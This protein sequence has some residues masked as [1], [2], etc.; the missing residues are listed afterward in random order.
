MNRRIV[1]M[2]AALGMAMLALA[3][4]EKPAPGISVVSGST[5]VRAEAVCWS[6]TGEPLDAAKCAEDALPALSGDGV[7]R[8]PVLAGQFVGISVDPS[9]AD[10]GWTVSVSGD[11]L[12][13]QALT[14]TYYR[15]PFPLAT[16]PGE[17]LS[18]EISAGNG[19]DLVGVWVFRLVPD[20]VAE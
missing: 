4:C 11:R 12:T 8:V 19:E 3:A 17:G 16:I 2:L 1:P 15:F 9:V 14:T 5:T 7:P 6:F 20:G 10:A 18:M 13:P